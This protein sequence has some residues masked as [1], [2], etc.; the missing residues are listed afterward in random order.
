M[1]DANS[2]ENH[3]CEFVLAEYMFGADP[4]GYPE[5]KQVDWGFGCMHWVCDEHFKEYQS[6]EST[7]KGNDMFRVHFINNY[8]EDIYIEVV[9]SADAETL[10]EQLRKLKIPADITG[11]R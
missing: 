3:P 10:V 2:S 1:T 4:C 7:T 6:M 8:G 5:T 9:S 11:V